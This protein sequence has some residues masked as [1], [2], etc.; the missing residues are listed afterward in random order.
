MHQKKSKALAELWVRLKNSL[1]I[2]IE[3]NAVKCVQQL[4]LSLSKRDEFK[5]QYDKYF[6]RLSYFAI[7]FTSF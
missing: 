5:V 4:H 6:Q 2:F 7:Y 3:S 1:N